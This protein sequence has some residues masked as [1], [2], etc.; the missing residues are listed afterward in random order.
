[1]IEHLPEELHASVGRAMRD[2]W[3]G[4]NA[5]L[6]KKQLQRLAPSLQAKH[7]GAAASLREGLEETLT[8]QAP[9]HHRRAVPHAAHHQPDREPQRLDRALHA[10]RQAL[11]GRADDAALGRQRAQRCQGPL[12]Q[13]ARV[14]RHEAALMAALDDASSPQTDRRRTARPRSI[15]NEEPSPRPRSTANGTSPMDP[16]TQLWLCS[17][18]LDIYPNPSCRVLRGEGAAT[19]G[20]QAR[21]SSRATSRRRLAAAV[22]FSA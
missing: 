16:S 19:T 15:T 12:P 2:A 18:P 3:D 9:G 10:Q 1:M 6:A 20:H 21:D 8:V 7:P 4:A 5:E 13:A 22:S 17:R 14:P 11:E